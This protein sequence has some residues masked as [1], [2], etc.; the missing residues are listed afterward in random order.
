METEADKY[1]ARAIEAEEN[2]DRARD[3]AAKRTWREVA[4]NLREL[5]VAEERLHPDER[6]KSKSAVGMSNDNLLR[7]KIR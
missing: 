5:A 6:I 1:W 7:H 2:A 3:V 4:S